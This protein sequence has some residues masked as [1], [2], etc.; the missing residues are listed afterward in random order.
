M[1]PLNGRRILVCGKGGSGKSTISTV[2]AK[3]LAEE[4]YKVLLIDGDSSNPSGLSRLAFGSQSPPDPLIDYFGGRQHVTCP[5]D[6]PSPLTRLND[7]QS[8]V[9][10]PIELKSVPD[11]YY[12]KNGN[13]FLFQVGKME[14]IHEGCDGPMSKVTRDFI[15]EGDF[16]TI[17]DTEAGIEHFGRGI[18]DHVDMVVVIVNSTFESLYL[19]EKVKNFCDDMNIDYV[20]A[21]VN[22][23]QSRKMERIITDS[24]NTRGV[25]ILDIVYFDP[26]LSL[27]GLT[28]DAISLKS[29]RKALSHIETR[30]AT[31]F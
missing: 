4:N 1:R 8:I 3:I 10:H 27:A 30:M 13:I 18:E 23:V 5:V 25:K 2:I 15:V 14:K 7:K 24:L 11:N 28:G 31:V 22:G 21:I 9:D 19:A 12:L 16:V 20:G 17:I 29:A 6:D 26:E